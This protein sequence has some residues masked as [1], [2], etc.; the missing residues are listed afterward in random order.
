[1]QLRDDTTLSIVRSVTKADG[2]SSECFRVTAWVRG[3]KAQNEQFSGL[4]SPYL[5]PAL[6][7]NCI[8]SMAVAA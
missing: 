6:R 3:G 8:S 5:G 1:M 7:G 2:Q 4:P